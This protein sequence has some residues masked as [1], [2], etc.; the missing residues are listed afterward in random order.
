M[1]YLAHHP[2]DG[3]AHR[4]QALLSVR[5][6][7]PAAVAR[8]RA[9]RDLPRPRHGDRAG[10]REA[11][12]VQGVRL[13]GGREGAP[14]VRGRRRHAAHPEHP[15]RPRGRRRAA[16]SL[17]DDS[18]ASGHLPMGWVPP[19]G[20]PDTGDPWRSAGLTLSRWN[21]HVGLAAGWWPA[22]HLKVPNIQKN[23]LPATLP[24]THGAL[25]DALAK[26]LVFR[27]LPAAHRDAVLAFLGVAASHPTRRR[28]RGRGLAP[29]LPGGAD[30]RHAQ[31]RDPVID[32]PRGTH[33]PR[34]TSRRS[35]QPCGCPAQPE[36][37]RRSFLKAAGATGIVAGLASEGMFTRL[38]FGATP[39]V[40]DVLVVLSLRGGM[41]SLQAVVP[42]R[43]GPVRP[44]REP[45]ARTSRCHRASCCR[46]T[47]T[48][49]CTPPWPR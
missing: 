22:N 12:P 13:L 6:R 30:P 28:R 9:R 42:G 35:P 18:R 15:P 2:V 8:R 31:P 7:R 26:R 33:R 11:V 36:I 46:S 37:S 47:R 32:M 14:P 44:L 20:Y 49:A 39:Y 1:N 27:K 5:L 4:P 41:D 24:K 19:D 40:G 45:S 23:V 16:G 29:A 34:S 48:S 25:V 10:A 38:A 21:M 17:L 43:G 3:R